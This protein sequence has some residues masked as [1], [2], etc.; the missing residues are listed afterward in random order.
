[1]AETE[2]LIPLNP[3]DLVFGV[4]AYQQFSVRVRA[5]LT[6]DDLENPDLWRHVV[7]KIKEGAE[8]RIL[9]YDMA[10]R[11]EALVTFCD[12][13]NIRVKVYSFAELLIAEKPEQADAVKDYTI[14]LRDASKWCIQRKSD[15][16]WI[17]EHIPTKNEA[18]TWLEKYLLATAGDK[19]AQAWFEKLDY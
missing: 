6:V 2:K 19:A 7:A 3:I 15:G 17:K 4:H 8:L 9:P 11:A 12:A 13:R 10:Y 1:M 14:K 5:G 18:V 16:E